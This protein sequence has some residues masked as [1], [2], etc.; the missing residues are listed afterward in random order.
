MPVNGAAIVMRVLLL[1]LILAFGMAQ[2]PVTAQTV[3]TARVSTIERIARLRVELGDAKRALGIA[4]P[5]DASGR[6]GVVGGSRSIPGAPTSTRA[7]AAEAP[8]RPPAAPVPTLAEIKAEQQRQN[9]NRAL[10]QLDRELQKQRDRRLDSLLL[11]K[12]R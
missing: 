11:E 9:A 8:S 10:D 7:P 3:D 2:K 5:D 4:E 1:G 12:L 6:R